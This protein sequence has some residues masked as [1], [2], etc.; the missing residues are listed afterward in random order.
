MVVGER[1]YET[2]EPTIDSADRYAAG[3]RRK[4]FFN[5]STPKFAAQAIKKV[6]EI[7]WKPLHMS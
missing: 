3:D 5:V 6:S 4:C 1:S 2:T 7:G